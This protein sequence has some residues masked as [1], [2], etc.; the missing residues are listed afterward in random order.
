MSMQFAAVVADFIALEHIAETE[1]AP[2]LVR[3]SV[4]L[5][6][7]RPHTWYNVET[8][9]TPNDRTNVVSRCP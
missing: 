5:P 3:E 9:R 6:K 7:T 8:G 2:D 1:E 4:C